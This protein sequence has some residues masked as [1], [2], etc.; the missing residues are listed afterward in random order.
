MVSFFLI[1]IVS[2]IIFVWLFSVVGMLNFLMVRVNVSSIFVVSVGESI[3][4]VM[5]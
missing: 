4:S 3:G 2:I 5:C 1:L